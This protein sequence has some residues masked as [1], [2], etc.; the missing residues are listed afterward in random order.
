MKIQFWSIGKA[1]ETYTKEGIE[2][3]TRRI[4]HY[5]PVEWIIV[6][7]PKLS[8]SATPEQQKKAE[9]EIILSRLQKSDFLIALDEHGRQW[10]SPQLADFIQSKMNDG[11]KNVLFMIGGAYGLDEEVLHR[12][13][14]V[15]SLSPL[16]FPH[17]IVRLILAE[18][19]YRAC[20]ILRNEKYHHS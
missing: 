15:W 10:S 19:V 11:T 17:Q 3:F 6:P 7:P 8:S 16:V 1:H 2:L 4:S 18:Q 14:A 13:N 5:F 20:T 9:G 12:A